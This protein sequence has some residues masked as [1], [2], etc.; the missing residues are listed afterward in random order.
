M[1]RQSTIIKAF[2]NVIARQRKAKGISQEQFAWNCKSSQKYISDIELGK[3]SVSLTFA[4]RCA[5]ALGVSLQDLFDMIEL[6]ERELN[7]EL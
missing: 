3:R 4:N 2:G 6:E 1:N 5:K 7:G